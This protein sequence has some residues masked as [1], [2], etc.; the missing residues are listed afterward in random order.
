MDEGKMTTAHRDMERI[1]A[2]V[3]ETIE[4]AGSTKSNTATPGFNDY[5]WSLSP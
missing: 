1:D 3:I 4:T 2:F 5:S